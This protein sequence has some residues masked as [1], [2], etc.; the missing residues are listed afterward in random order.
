MEAAGKH[1]WVLKMYNLG[2]A[3]FFQTV[4][5]LDCLKRFYRE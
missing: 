2:K 3:I 4:F 1:Y 5:I